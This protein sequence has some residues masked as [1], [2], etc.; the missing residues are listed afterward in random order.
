MRACRS[1][2]GVCYHLPD[3]GV[4]GPRGSPQPSAG[5]RRRPGPA[6]SPPNLGATLG[7]PAGAAGAGTGRG[8]RQG[9]TWKNHP[10]CIAV[11]EAARRSRFPRAASPPG[12]LGAR[13]PGARPYL[14]REVPPGRGARRLAAWPGA[15]QCV[16]RSSEVPRRA[17]PHVWLGEWL[18]SSGNPAPLLLAGLGVRIIRLERAWGET[19]LYYQHSGQG[20][21]GAVHV[22][23]QSPGSL[24]SPRFAFFLFKEVRA[25]VSDSSR[26]NFN[27]LN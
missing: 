1:G 13:F 3:C 8:A 19:E 16:P 2:C 23:I 12:F 6:S 11:G 26:L 14:G 7:G 24:L 20:F 17:A 21:R 15:P 25:W 27:L 5:S 10:D 22:R 18:E 4:R 9:G